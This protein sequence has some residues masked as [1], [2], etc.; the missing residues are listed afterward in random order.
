L[1]NALAGAVRSFAADAR[2]VHREQS[3]H[4]SLDD[5]SARLEIWLASEQSSPSE[6][7]SRNEQLLQLAKALEQLPADQREAVQLHHL[8]N[9]PVAEV[10]ER[11]G[12][13]KD[14]V[15]GLLFRGLRKLRALL[16]EAKEV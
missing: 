7:V 8:Q 4:T 15:V 6:R 1:A 2:N 13:S 9:L 11:M 14:A 16:Q 3:L 10:A 12:R 5:S